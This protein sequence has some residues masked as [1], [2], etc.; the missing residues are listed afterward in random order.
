MD[1]D[2]TI[3]TIVRY[4]RKKAGLTQIELAD[5][6]DVGK[7]S[8]HEVETGHPTVQL[9][10]L[11]SICQVLN[12]DICLKSPLMEQPM[13]IDNADIPARYKE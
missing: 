4:H 8:I 12:I 7:A 10:T 2:I 6:A 3:G 9:E 13:L 1:Y 5:L 11:R